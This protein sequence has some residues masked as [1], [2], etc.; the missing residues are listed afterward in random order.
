MT[1]QFSIA[2]GCIGLV[3]SITTLSLKLHDVG[4]SVKGAASQMTSVKTELE[5]LTR[6]LLQIQDIPNEVLLPI[7]IS[8][9]LGK[10]LQ[11]CATTLRAAET[12]Y[13][14]LKRS[15]LRPLQ[16][17][18]SGKK[19][20]VDLLRQIEAYKSTVTTTLIFAAAYARAIF[21]LKLQLANEKTGSKTT[22]QTARRLS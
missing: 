5:N 14:A 7:T 8:K 2:P 22:L 9:S 4:G 18:R 13:Q 16:W 20:T 17:V 1:D 21:A 15:R 11:N 12:K 3:A 19:D 6:V 10:I